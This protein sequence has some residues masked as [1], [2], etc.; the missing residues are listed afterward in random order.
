MVVVVQ[1]GTSTPHVDLNS[2][3][4]LPQAISVSI[5]IIVF[6]CYISHTAWVAMKFQINTT[7]VAMK[8]DISI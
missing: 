8:G 7:I 4:L 6:M 3:K 2:T 1:C 5:V